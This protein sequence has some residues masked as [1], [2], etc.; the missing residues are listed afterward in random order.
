MLEVKKAVFP[1][2][3]QFDVV[4]NGMRN[5]YDSWNKSD[6][7]ICY[8]SDKELCKYC[9]G[10]EE[11]NTRGCD[12]DPPI[13][14]YVLGEKD[15]KLAKNLVNSG[16]E[17]AK[18]L[19]QLPVI[20]DIKAP[21]YWWRQCDQYKVGTTTDS[22]S[23][24]HT[25]LKNAF[26][27]SDFSFEDLPGWKNVIEQKEPNLTEK[28]IEDEIWIDYEGY[29]VSNLGRLK[30]SK[31]NIRKTSV[32]SSGYKKTTINGKQKYIHRIIAQ[33][34]VLNP[35][36]KPY[37]NHID[38]NKLNNQAENLEW[39]TAKENKEHAIKNNLVAKQCKNRPDIHKFSDEEIQKIKDEWETGKFNKKEIA[40]MHGCY[41]STICDIVNNNYNYVPVPN[42]F[43]TIAIP[44]VETLNN[45][46]DD[47]YNE[48]DEEIRKI[49]WGQ[50]LEIT[51]QSYNQLRTWSGSYANLFNICLQRAGHP[52]K[53]WNTFIKWIVN[54]VPYF[55]ELCFD[56]LCKISKP[57]R[58][59]FEN[60]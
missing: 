15:L 45:L 49:I 38:G 43:Q 9:H 29:Q 39:V 24:M 32:N 21:I 1:S 26:K 57:F 53:E 11:L 50:I 16:V 12:Y 6:S 18:F 54:N 7:G 33:A 23:Q 31:G 41:T 30:D 20:I 46:R 37:V 42:A 22:C 2:F 36:N 17:H 5:P 8:G 34:F 60:E 47:Y 48:P 40:Q 59:L 10:E 56:R 35:E 13:P 19:R 14:I 52:L 27:V 28:Q 4:F 3:E 55:R 25:L 44:L 51:P 58:E